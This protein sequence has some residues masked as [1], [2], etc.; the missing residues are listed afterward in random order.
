[1][2]FDIFIIEERS[3]FII[4]AKLMTNL[5]NFDAA[6]FSG[7]RKLDMVVGYFAFCE[8]STFHSFDI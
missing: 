5:Q 8:L 6:L 2:S 3:R 4:M 7:R 1:M